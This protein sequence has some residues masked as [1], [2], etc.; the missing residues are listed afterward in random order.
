LAFFLKKSIVRPSAESFETGLIAIAAFQLSSASAFFPL[1]DELR[2]HRIFMTVNIISS[3]KYLFIAF[4]NKLTTIFRRRM[5]SLEA[6]VIA[7]PCA[8]ND[9]ELSTKSPYYYTI[10]SNKYVVNDDDDTH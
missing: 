6:I 9:E 7:T 5:T 10:L 2:V 4:K 3:L 8:D 1:V